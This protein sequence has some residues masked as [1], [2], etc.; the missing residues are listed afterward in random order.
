VSG[1]V[2]VGDALLDRDIQ[3]RVERSCPEAPAP[4]LDEEE[5]VARPG[6]AGLAAVLAAADGHDV[7][8]VT[9]FAGDARARELRS[10]L[11]AAGVQVI[12]LGLSGRTPTKVR[13]RNDGVLLLRLDGNP[14]RSVVGPATPASR[15]ALAAA[16]GVLVSDY[17]RGVAG[18]LGMRH[19][20][21]SAA[22]RIPLVWDP[23][24]RGEE[25]VAWSLLACPNRSEAEHFSGL[26]EAAWAGRELKRR[27]NVCSVAVTLGAQGAV[28]CNGGD[29]FFVAAPPASGDTC[30]A[31][32]RF[33]SAAVQEL[34]AGARLAEAVEAAVAAASRFVDADGAS[35]VRVA[36]VSEAPRGKGLEA[37]LARTRAAGGT[38]VATGGCFDILHAGH[39]SLLARA[40]ELGDCLVVCLN[41]DRS[42][43][44]LKGRDRPYVSAEDRTA[45][46]EA[47]ECVDGVAVFEEDTPAELLARVRPDVWVKGGDYDAR[48]LPETRLVESWG[49]RVAIVPYVAGRSTTRIV[50]EISLRA[51]G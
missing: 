13:L 46:L 32:D 14:G 40:R 9:A 37:V 22:R 1:L 18:A 19:E 27:W 3:G 7:T 28:V 8:L 11:R 30:G 42:V 36:P 20:L 23:H 39:V 16:E 17:G 12:D 38:V 34:A 47:L 51:A 4:V 48:E 10:L 15:A 5:C 6:G 24:P 26:G 41:S 44:R 33:A 35:S 31:G 2:V 25:P 29:P 50:K 49:G 43:R 21:E 45:I